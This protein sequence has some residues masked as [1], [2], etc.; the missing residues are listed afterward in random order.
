M[1][2]RAL[3]KADVGVV[4]V[5]KNSLHTQLVHLKDPV[6]HTH[7]SSVVDHIP[8]TG[9]NTD[10]CDATYIGETERSMDTRFKEHHSKSKSKIKPLTGNYASAVGQHAPTTGHHFLPE[11]VTYLDRESDKLARGIKEAIYTR[12]LNPALNKGG[13]LRYILPATYDTVI[14]S[15]VKPPKPPPPNAP[16]LPPPAFD[17][18]LPKP[19]GRQPG[20]KNVVKCLPL[21]DAAIKAAAHPTMTQPPSAPLTAARRPGRPRKDTTTNNNETVP[22][23][24]AA[25]TAPPAPP[26]HGMTTRA[27]TLRSSV[28]DALQSPPATRL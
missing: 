16:G 25:I 20:A 19:K 22:P 11:D 8:C 9:S 12:T 13:G 17:N 3:R 21:V 28:R 4:A 5:N 14:N 27:R 24:T 7:K 18:N 2:G 6:L 10:P 1:V 15:T 26:P 23:A